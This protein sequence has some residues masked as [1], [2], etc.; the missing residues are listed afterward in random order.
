MITGLN[1][2]NQKFVD[3][4]RRITDRLNNDQLQISSGL[5]MRQVSDSPDQ[6]SVLL[7][8]RAALSSSQQISSNLGNVKSEVDMGEQ[9]LQSAVQLFDQV[10]TLAAQG[11]TGTQTAAARATLAQQLQ[12]IEQQYVGLANT[13]IEGRF[14]FSGDGDQTQPYTY[15]ITQTNP[16][17]PYQGALSTRVAL[18]PNGTTFPVALTAQQI[19]D[20]ADPTTNVFGA[21]SGLI[22]ALKNND[23][24]ATLTS[25]DGLA[26]VA[27][28]LNNQLA[29]YGTTQ[30]KIDSAIDFAAS[31]Q[32]SLKSEISGLQDADISTSILDMTQTETQQQAALQSKAQIPRSTLFDFLA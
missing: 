9:T 26:K 19:F 23:Q 21:L 30:S 16:V 24:A 5:R 2:G 3:N 10:Q 22:T 12:S 17:S 15:D 27:Q 8:A 4:L 32:T 25:M 28:H 13:S 29:F 6:V 14:I 1:S 18:H 11:S 7:Q 31:Q 20:S